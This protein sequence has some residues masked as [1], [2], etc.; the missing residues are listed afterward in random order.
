MILDEFKK[1][2]IIGIV[3]DVELEGIDAFTEALVSSGLKTMEVTMNTPDVESI[4]KAVVKTAANRLT[5]GAGTVLTID[6]VKR[7]VNS[8]ATF[9]VMPIVI[10]TVVEYCIQEKIPVF[11]GAFSPQEVYNA[12]MLEVTMVKIFPAKFFGPDYCK[13]IKGPFKDIDFLSCGGVTP[14]N[15]NLF[16]NAGAAAV[17]FGSSIFAKN[18]LHQK[19]FEVI[20]SKIKELITAYNG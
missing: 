19:K 7:A 16:F 5:I 11:P 1:L 14:E 18:L 4:L 17:A 2:P 3:R 20:E 10:P 12:W 9:I 6:D 13:T 8:G 15:I